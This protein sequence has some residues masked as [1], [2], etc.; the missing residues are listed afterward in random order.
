MPVDEQGREYDESWDTTTGMLDDCDGL[1][2]S[3]RFGTIDKYKDKDG[4]LQCLAMLTIQPLDDKGRPDGEP[5]EQS[6]S[7]GAGWEPS[8]E[9]KVAIHSSGKRKFNRSSMY[10]RLCTRTAQLH[11][12]VKFRGVTD[13][14]GSLDG[15]VFHWEQE[16]FAYGGEIGDRDHLMPSKFIREQKVTAAGGK[17]GAKGSAASSA[18]SG[19]ADW[20]E[21]AATLAVAEE[22]HKAFVKEVLANKDLTNAIKASGR[23]KEVLDGKETGFWHKARA[24]AG[25]A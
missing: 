10:G 12:D 25:V 2:V 17:G 14:A 6:W 3:S 18:A 19:G 7:C 15:L 24:E 1:V 4:N 11:P 5:V 16:K 8:D 23:L 9:G 21:D 22:D 20:E 13:R